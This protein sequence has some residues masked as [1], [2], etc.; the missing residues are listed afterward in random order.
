MPG[1]TGITHC[2]LSAASS[3]PSCSYSRAPAGENHNAQDTPANT[4]RCAIVDCSM[5]GLAPG[6]KVVIGRWLSAGL[7]PSAR[8]T[9]SR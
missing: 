5:T 2:G 6:P 8:R 1:A 3:A 4:A 7:R 9:R